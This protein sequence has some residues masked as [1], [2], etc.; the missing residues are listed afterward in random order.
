MIKALCLPRY[1]LINTD[2]IIFFFSLHLLTAMAPIIFLKEMEGEC[3]KMRQEVEEEFI[4]S[5]IGRYRGV[6]EKVPS[7]TCVH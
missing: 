1:R 5:C 4:N 2:T 6:H 7:A 3:V